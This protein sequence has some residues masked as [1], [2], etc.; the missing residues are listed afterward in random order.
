MVII[1]ATAILANSAAPEK[2]RIASRLYIFYR[3]CGVM[4]I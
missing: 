1:I 2:K 3:N 4:E